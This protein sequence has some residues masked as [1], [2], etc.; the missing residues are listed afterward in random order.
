MVF[1]WSLQRI[2]IKFTLKFSKYTLGLKLDEITQS[3]PRNQSQ[4]LNFHTQ[5][6]AQLYP[7]P[8]C[9]GLMLSIHRTIVVYAAFRTLWLQSLR[10]RHKKLTVLCALL[11]V[12]S[13]CS[14]QL[15]FSLMV[16]PKYL[17]DV[18]ISRV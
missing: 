1:F 15:S 12:F 2:G 7:L 4:K 5:N 6:Y 13:V 16:T 9:V 17:L 11:A 8:V 3:K 14:L 10:S 18:S